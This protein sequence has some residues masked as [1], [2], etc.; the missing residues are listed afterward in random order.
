MKTEDN[1]ETRPGLKQQQ[2]VTLQ[3][4]FTSTVTAVASLP[5]VERRKKG[6][7]SDDCRSLKERERERV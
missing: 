6:Q 1:K 2:Q 5:E 3:D 7:E 4:C